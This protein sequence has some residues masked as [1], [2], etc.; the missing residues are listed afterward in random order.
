MKLPTGVK[1]LRESIK[2]V[3]EEK[4]VQLT[5]GVKYYVVFT[6]SE[7]KYGNVESIKMISQGDHNPEIDEEGRWSEIFWGERLQYV[8]KLCGYKEIED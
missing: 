8:L 6:H 7:S 5:T 2:L 1:A 3:C 4:R